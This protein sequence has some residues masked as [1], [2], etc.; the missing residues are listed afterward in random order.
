M[1]P[2]AIDTYPQPVTDGHGPVTFLVPGAPSGGRQGP[3]LHNN[4]TTTT[5]QLHNNLHNN[6][7]N[8]SCCLRLV[9]IYAIEEVHIFYSSKL[10]Q[11]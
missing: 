3:R 2:D 4:Y 9:R 11:T 10:H 1:R 7:H 8:K 5:Q 6:L